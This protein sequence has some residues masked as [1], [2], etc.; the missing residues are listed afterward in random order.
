MLMVVDLKL[1]FNFVFAFLTIIFL[2][3]HSKIQMLRMW[4]LLQTGSSFK[5]FCQIANRI[6]YR[7]R[8][9]DL[10][11]NLTFIA[12]WHVG[13]NGW[14]VIKRDL[15]IFI[16]L[17]KFETWTKMRLNLNRFNILKYDWIT[18]NLFLLT[19]RMLQH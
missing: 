18:E 1:I 13:F 16:S 14:A 4:F 5:C 17:P 12:V 7:I 11:S 19:G 3:M 6:A 2:R 9:D 15:A 8:L 10:Q